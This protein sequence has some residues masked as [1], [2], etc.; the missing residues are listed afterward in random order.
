MAA[1]S[2]AK[3]SATSNSVA[4]EKR[5]PRA[6]KIKTRSGGTGFNSLWNYERD[7]FDIQSNLKSYY[8]DL[9]DRRKYN[10]L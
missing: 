4:R 6:D 7:F 10:R 3:L 5:R 9:G 2:N 1:R 8:G